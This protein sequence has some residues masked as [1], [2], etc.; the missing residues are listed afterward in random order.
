MSTQAQKER[1][2]KAKAEGICTEKVN[3]LKSYHGRSSFTDT[4]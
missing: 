4:N 3:H 1:G 2:R